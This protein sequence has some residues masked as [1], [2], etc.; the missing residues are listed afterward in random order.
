[1]TTH[2]SSTP[3]A[4]AAARDDSHA[5]ERG[6]DENAR[7]NSAGLTVSGLNVRFDETVAVDDVTFHVEPGKVLALLGP[8]GCGK[9]TLLRAITGLQPYARGEG[10]WAGK[11]IDR[12]PAQPRELGHMFQDA[13]LFQHRRSALRV[14]YGRRG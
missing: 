9:S 12:V 2:A 6:R 8:S 1:M 14:S 7:N 5:S 10:A 3:R 4:Q 11:A 13:Q